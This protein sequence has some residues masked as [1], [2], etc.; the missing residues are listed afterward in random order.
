MG[1]RED[2]LTGAKRCLAEKGYA[3]TTAR[4]IVAAAG[5][6]LGSIG[7]HFGSKEALLN[8]A[9]L[10]IFD[11]WGDAIGAAV[12]AEPGGAPLDRLRRFLQGVFEAAHEQRAVLVASVQAYAQAEFAPEVRA[13][14]AAGYVASRRDLAALTLDVAPTEV[15]AEQARR[16][17]SLALALINGAMLQL[18]LD[19][20]SA[21]SADDLVL[22]VEGLTGHG[23]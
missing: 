19:P 17:G 1:Q 6:H 20:T 3:H 18:L 13:Q 21:P 11:A 22:A 14:L 23:R 16:Y 8:A 15:S 2:L 12:V 7:Y 9:V 4:D 10:E 5:A